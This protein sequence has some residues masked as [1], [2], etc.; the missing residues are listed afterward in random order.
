MAHLPSPEKRFVTARGCRLLHPFAVY[1]RTVAALG[2]AVHGVAARPLQRAGIGYRLRPPLRAQPERRFR[3]L[4]PLR[5]RVG[6]RSHSRPSVGREWRFYQF[7]ADSELAETGRC[8]ARQPLFGLSL[9]PGREGSE[10]L[11]GGA[12]VRIPHGESP[13]LVHG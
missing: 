1:A 7:V 2:T 12:Q 6:H 4:L 13:A 11:S 9:L 5:E 3:R 10:R 8:G